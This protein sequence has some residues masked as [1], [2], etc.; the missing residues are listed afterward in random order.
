MGL[1]ETLFGVDDS[2]KLTKQYITTD[3]LKDSKFAL[4][5]LILAL[6]ESSN[7][8]MRQVLKKEF[9]TAL[10]NHFRLLDISGEYDWY[11]PY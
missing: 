5:S 1:L 3:M 7:P 6:S 10:Q 9:N 4:Y 2:G 11:H 8:Q